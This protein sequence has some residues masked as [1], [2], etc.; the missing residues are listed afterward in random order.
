MHARQV[1]FAHGSCLKLG[2]QLPRGCG[3]LS[4]DENAGCI[5]VES[6]DRKHLQVLEH[7][8]QQ[9]E[10]RVL[11]ET[12][13]RMNRQWR[14]L[15]EHHDVLVFVKESKLGADVWL[16]LRLD[17]MDESVSATD[18]LIEAVD[19]PS[20]DFEPAATKGRSPNRRVDVRVSGR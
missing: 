10:H 18:R 2:A 6:V 5:G 8:S 4:K 20:I 16:D 14:R 11:V 3:M 17:H 12:T 19:R 15:V 7:R 13:A 9:P 1:A